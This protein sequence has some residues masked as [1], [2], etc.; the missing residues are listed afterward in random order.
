MKKKIIALAL[1]LVLASIA[2]SYFAE[3]SILY[4]D[5]PYQYKKT[6][7]QWF[8]IDRINNLTSPG[9]YT[10]VQC[11]NKGFFDLHQF[12]FPDSDNQQ[13]HNK[14]NLCTAQPRKNFDKSLLCCGPK[15][16]QI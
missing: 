10:T 8:T 3:A 7:G 2:F 4:Q 15:C 9:T 1:I 5:I 14:S 16:Y 6:G 12:K 11:Q 13:N